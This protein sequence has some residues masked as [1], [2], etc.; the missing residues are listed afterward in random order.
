MSSEDFFLSLASGRF[1]RKIRKIC[2]GILYSVLYWCKWKHGALH[3]METATNFAVIFSVRLRQIVLKQIEYTENIFFMVSD[4]DVFFHSTICF[5]IDGKNYCSVHNSVRTGKTDYL[6]DRTLR[7]ESA[8]SICAY[9]T[10][11]CVAKYNKLEWRSVNISHAC[12]P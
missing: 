9:K 2:S 11:N 5:A 12:F 3:I 7:N 6:F 4:R 1:S 10:I 8:E